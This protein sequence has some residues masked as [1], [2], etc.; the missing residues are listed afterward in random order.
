MNEGKKTERLVQAYLERVPA[1]EGGDA[2]AKGLAAALTAMYE[3]KRH[4]SRSGSLT[5]KAIMTSR[6]PRFAAAAGVAVAVLFA[7]FHSLT[8]PAWALEDAIE[9]LEDFH[10]VHV[11]GAFPGGTADVW[12]RANKA[13]THTTDVVVRSSHGTVTWTRDGS[14]Y[15]Y[16]PSQRTVFYE[17]A[18]TIGMGQWLGPDLLEKLRTAENAKVIFGKD[19][20]TGRDRV[21]L[22]CSL[23]D[24]HGAQSF[25]IEFDRSTKL[26]VAMR[27]WQNLDRS[28]SP[29]FDAV[30][31]TYYEDLPDTLF[32]VRIPNDA[33]HVEKPLQIPDEA[34]RLLGSPRDGIPTQGLTQQ[35]AAEKTVR[36]LYQ[37]V[38]DQNLS[39]LKTISPLC[40]NLGDEFL[41]AIIL[42]PHEETRIVEILEIGQISKTGHSALG[43]IAAIPT[44][45]RLKNGKKVE[46]KMIVQFRQFGDTTSSVVHGPY[47][48]PREVE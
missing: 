45:V 11:V 26:P 39:T 31:I 27:Q 6:A 15:H 43:P 4:G 7:V 40:Q 8:E 35:E 24:V 34:V 29:S 41:R 12:M 32:D 1:P 38:I 46:E 10:A 36:A 28:G 13:R 42:K 30:K 16:E 21:T 25:A 19:P 48:L 17:H 14:T 23:I 37:A 18:L 20:A 2:D 44:T 9:A 33:K 5:W 47:G 3:A 22:L